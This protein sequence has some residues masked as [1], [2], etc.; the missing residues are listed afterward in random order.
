MVARFFSTLKQAA[1]VGL[2]LAGSATAS[3]LH[4]RNAEWLGGHFVGLEKGLVTW[5]NPAFV[6]PF[7]V[8]VGMIRRII[9]F[10]LDEA[11]NEPWSIRL[12]DGSRLYGSIV[13][14]SKETLEVKSPRYGTISILRDAVVSVRKLK[15]DGLLF[16]HPTTPSAWK[17]VQ[18]TSVRV[19][20]K[21][22]NSTWRTVPG[23]ALRQAAWNRKVNLPIE[24]PEKVE[25]QVTLRAN[26]RPEFKLEIKVGEGESVAL[27]TWVDELVLQQE[28]AFESIKVLQET[29][30]RVVLTLCWDRKTRACAVYNADGKKMAEVGPADDTAEQEEET[31]TKE[32]AEKKEAPKPKVGGI[33]GALVGMV[34]GAADA[35]VEAIKAERAKAVRQVMV[36][37]PSPAGLTLLNK[38]PELTLEALR[39]RAWNGLPPKEQTGQRPRVELA[40]G[41]SL[42]AVPVRCTSTSLTY[43]EERGKETTLPWD[44]VLAVEMAEGISPFFQ[45]A[46]PSTELWFTDGEWLQ[47]QLLEVKNETATLKTAFSNGLVNFKIQRMHHLQ[48]KDD[49]KGVPMPDLAKLDKMIA[50]KRPLHGTLEAVGGAQPQWRVIGSPEAVALAEAKDLVIQRSVAMVTDTKGAESLFY[51]ANG[52][53]VPGQLKAMDARRVDL[54][55]DVTAL[56]HLDTKKLCAVQFGGKALN[57]EGFEDSG[58]QC[59]RGDSKELKR[60]G[61]AGLNLSS[62]IS[63]GHPGFMQVNKMS[64]NLVD[65]GFS[66]LRVRLFADL[67]NLA[68]PSTNLL[69]AH[70]GSEVSFGME[71]AGEQ[72]D[73]QIRL[74][75]TGDIPVR[76]EVAEDG[77]EIFLNNSSV[78]KLTAE[79][80]KKSGSGVVFEPFS[81]WGNGE[82]EVRIGA[83]A[84]TT[85]IGRVAAPTVD[86]VSK[87]NAL[88]VPRFRKEDPPKHA[89]V[90]ANG[91]LL[92]GV[93]EAATANHISL[94]S[95]LETIQVPRDRVKAVVWLVSPV[96]DVSAAFEARDQEKVPAKI[97]HWLQLADGGRLGLNVEQFA[98]G[99]VIGKSETLGDCRI[100]LAKVY[101]I[102]SA[103]PAD[104]P[105]MLALKDWKL[106]YAPEPVLPET[107]GQSSPLL[108]QEA[109]PFKLPLLGG[110]EFDLAKERGKVIVLDF[111]ATW[112]GPCIKSLPG[113]LDEMAAFDVK[114][115][116]MIGVNQAEAQDHVKSFLE[117]RGW[118]LETVLDA[119]QRV[120]QSYGVEG[121]PH[122]VVIGPDG[123]VALVKTG[124]ESEGARKIAETVRKLLREKP[125]ELK[126]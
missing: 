56:R 53:V 121:I 6:T 112:C 72:M 105:A 20:N 77:V 91:D 109:K 41:R 116:R 85:S 33:L 118:K 31:A 32:A 78:R 60:M 35:K 50:D 84:A 28:T 62:G 107:G 54:E 14:M 96:D 1:A 43:R 55:S 113:L 3:E 92:R 98:S 18:D 10:K 67:G 99:T 11:T 57:L 36:G 68:A 86:G 76:I 120:G 45:M 26:V 44:Q 117:T 111:W 88:T 70:M 122:T 73:R 97:T 7:K 52:E 69:F 94:R 82:R 63:W 48:F 23:A 12:A 39:V 74:G 89:L 102:Q 27:E 110:G 51:L 29:E 30:R 9:R 8:D 103:R 16:A 124:F 42:K 37:S 61:K 125:A 87:T 101:Q 115:V 38:G 83:F 75:A 24:V 58:W 71:S 123:K 108:N 100:P 79:Q 15:A 49:G 95:G 5:N 93:I 25:M 126:K 114:Q 46:P 34:Q 13:G 80:L 21:N 119:N 66:T 4:W 64:F 2:L 106:K 22:D 90:A 17:E 19:A 40:D 47:G 81:L 104:S 59:V 65:R